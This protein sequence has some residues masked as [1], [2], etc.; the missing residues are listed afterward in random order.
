MFH[1]ATTKKTYTVEPKQINIDVDDKIIVLS[2]YAPSLKGY[3]VPTTQT[4]QISIP[5]DIVIKKAIVSQSNLFVIDSEGKLY[6]CK[7][8][9]SYSILKLV[10]TIND[11]VLDI[12]GTN[13]HLFLLG[14]SKV[15]GMGKN[16]YGQLGLGHLDTVHDFVPLNFFDRININSKKYKDKVVKIACGDAFTLFFTNTKKIYTCGSNY[17]GQQTF[18]NDSVYLSTPQRITELK[19]NIVDVYCGRSYSLFKLSDGSYVAYGQFLGETPLRNTK[20]I[21]TLQQFD[22]GNRYSTQIE[23]Q[24]ND[25]EDVLLFC[26]EKTTNNMHIQTTDGMNTVMVE[27]TSV[28]EPVLIVN[29]GTDSNARVNFNDDELIFYKSDYSPHQ[30]EKSIYQLVSEK[31]KQ[32]KLSSD[33]IQIGNSNNIYTFLAFIQIR[34]PS[35]YT[36]LKQD[37]LVNSENSPNILQDLVDYCFSENC[38]FMKKYSTSMIAELLYYLERM[39]VDFNDF[40]APLMYLSLVHIS[41]CIGF[42]PIADKFIKMLKQEGIDPKILGK[43][44][45]TFMKNGNFATLPTT[46]SCLESLFNSD[47]SD[48]TIIIDQFGTEKIKCHRS[49]LIAQSTFFEAF[50]TGHFA[51]D[52][53]NLFNDEDVAD[54]ALINFAEMSDEEKQLLIDPESQIKTRALKNILMMFYGI[55]PVVENDLVIPMLDIAHKLDAEHLVMKCLKMFETSLDEESLQV[56]NQWLSGVED[57]TDVQNMILKSADNWSNEISQ[58]NILFQNPELENELTKDIGI[59]THYQINKEFVPNV[60]THFVANHLNTEDYNFLCAVAG[61]CA[62]VKPEYIQKSIE[63]QCWIDEEPYLFNKCAHEFDSKVQTLLKVNQNHKALKT[64]VFS[65]MTGQVLLRKHTK[66]RVECLIRSGGGKI[67]NFY[68]NLVLINKNTFSKHKKIGAKCENCV[69]VDYRNLVDILMGENPAKHEIHSIHQ[70][71][72]AN[73]EKKKRKRDPNEII[74]ID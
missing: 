23:Y 65:H 54:G 32:F 67:D 20:V 21:P 15:Y 52:E 70:V 8:S 14:K 28:N 33:T 5:N 40:T 43:D 22:R 59:L 63:S 64:F 1:F 7:Y 2:V 19:E 48:T 57:K 18:E 44:L 6:K 49:V 46:H 3:A 26:N 45:S 69:V 36:F 68:A 30:V 73:A 61:N 50:Y 29:F 9:E 51:S 74:E 16:D 55:E 66:S 72:I 41:K 31:A 62:I 34:N 39:C 53:I 60:T 17:Y 47:S 37:N 35:F 24:N 25:S 27:N 4:Y 56:I 71:A 11:S 13:T 10:D 38:S 58:R 12:V 42:E